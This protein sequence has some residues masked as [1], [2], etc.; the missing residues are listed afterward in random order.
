LSD[1]EEYVKVETLSQKS[2]VLPIFAKEMEYL[3]DEMLSIFNREVKES[4]KIVM[5]N[6]LYCANLNSYYRE[7]V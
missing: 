1:D 6:L 2:Y 3:G 7:Y 4:K 5:G